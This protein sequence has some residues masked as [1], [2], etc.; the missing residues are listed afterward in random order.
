MPT[1][2]AVSI[3]QQSAVP[4]FEQVRAQLAAGIA[5]H[6][7]AVGL[8]LPTVRQFAADLGLAANTVARA[9]RELEEAGLIETR[10]RAGTFVSAGGD[11]S[12]ERARRAAEHYA[13][14]VLGLGL[15]AEEAL[16]IV[17]AALT[18]P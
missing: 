16:R 1:Q 6:S 5:D 2:P 14:T 10:G 13:S 17:R 8:R 7:L 12:L 18:R 4:P 3:D 15:D 11:H 9:Y